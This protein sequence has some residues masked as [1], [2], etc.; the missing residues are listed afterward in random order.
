M[1]LVEGSLLGE[2]IDRL[3][4]KH[5]VSL[6]QEYSVNILS[7]PQ[8]PGALLLASAESSP[9]PDSRIQCV[10]EVRMV[11]GPPA[12]LG[13]HTSC[14]L[15]E[16]RSGVAGSAGD[17]VDW[18]A[19]LVD[20]SISFC[21]GLQTPDVPLPVYSLPPA[22]PAPALFEMG[23]GLGVE[24]AAHP[25]QSPSLFHPVAAL[26]PSEGASAPWAPFG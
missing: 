11:P 12:R 23:S 4:E 5:S 18:V 25:H 2:L 3:V 6:T 20:G 1:C 21:E 15:A 22:V 10:Q 7:Q 8:V 9:R 14:F 26:G 19:V 16:D 24:R 17:C 13:V